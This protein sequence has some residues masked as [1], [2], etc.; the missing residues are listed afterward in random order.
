MGVG[1]DLVEARGVAEAV[2]VEIPLPGERDAQPLAHPRARR[3]EQRRDLRAAARGRVE[4]VSR[5]LG[6]A[7]IHN[8][9]FMFF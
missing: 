3:G 7:E 6:S 5:Q 2:G 1:E 8:T 9:Q 4:R